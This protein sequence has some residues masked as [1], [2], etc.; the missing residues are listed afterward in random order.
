MKRATIYFDE[1]L[2]KALKIKAAEC[3]SSLSE[4]VNDAVKGLLLEDAEDLQAI[5]E[6]K[7]EKPMSNEKFV[8]KL[9][10]SGKI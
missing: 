2:H 3:E 5:T 9:K 6:R 4:L 10:K 7:N 1:N 8:K